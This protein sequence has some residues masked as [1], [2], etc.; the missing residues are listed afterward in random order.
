MDTARPSGERRPPE[1]NDRA[2]R[3][4]KQTNSQ[5]IARLSRAFRR[6]V[7]LVVVVAL[8]AT[9]GLAHAAEQH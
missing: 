3:M 2:G 9:A 8:F 6:L 1:L 5:P 4:V 7:P